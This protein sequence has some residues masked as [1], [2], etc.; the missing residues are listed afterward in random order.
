MSM[1][2][3]SH[4]ITMIIIGGGQKLYGPLL[5]AFVVMWLREF[6]DIYIA[7]FL[8]RM[9]AEVDALFFGVIIVLILMFMPG[10]LTGWVE[11]FK[12]AV[13]RAYMER[14]VRERLSR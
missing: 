9:T 1:N 14:K 7:K 6:I 13:K 12:G 4:I 2:S 11:Q 10:G 5:G 3:R 8:P